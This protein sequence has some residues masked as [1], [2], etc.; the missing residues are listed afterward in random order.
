MALMTPVLKG[1]LTDQGFKMRQRCLQMHGGTG[2][3]G[4]QGVEQFVR[5]AGS[6]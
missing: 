5:D 1:F 3:I 6:P 2:Y 4:D